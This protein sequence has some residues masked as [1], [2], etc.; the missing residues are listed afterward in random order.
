MTGGMWKSKTKYCKKKVI[1]VQ[2]SKKKSFINI[3]TSLKYGQFVLSL[4]LVYFFWSPIC[5]QTTGS[6]LRPGNCLASMMVIHTWKSWDFRW[7][8]VRVIDLILL[9]LNLSVFKKH[10][11]H[12]HFPV[13]ESDWNLTF[14]FHVTGLDAFI[15]SFGF[16]LFIRPG[17][18]SWSVRISY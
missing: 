15:L 14:P 1:F 8:I 12:L 11:N 18:Q 2:V 10:R 16:V 7:S 4:T 3:F 9:R 17:W 6:I 5:M 13:V